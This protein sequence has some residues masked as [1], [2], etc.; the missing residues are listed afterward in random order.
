MADL[1]ISDLVTASQLKNDDY[2]EISQS[3]SGTRVSYK[4]T[5][6][7]I[8]VQ[9]ATMVD[10]TSDLNTT[11]KKITGAINELKN[12]ISLIPQFS[13]EVVETLP[14]EDISDTTIYLVPAEDPEVGNYYEEYI[15]VN[16]T[17]ELVGTTA[18]DLSDYYTKA[19]ADGKFAVTIANTQASGATKA[20]VGDFTQNGVTTSLYADDA[21]K[22][23]RAAFGEHEVT[24]NPVSFDAYL[25]LEVPSKAEVSFSPI[26]DLHGYDNPCVGG[27]GKNKLPNTYSTTTY[28]GITYT[29]SSDGKVVAIGKASGGNSILD[30]ATNLI[31][32]SGTYKINGISGGETST[33]RMRYQINGGSYNNILSGE[34]E[35]TVNGT[36]ELVVQIVMFSGY[37]CPTSGITFEP[38]IRLS[39]ETDDTFEPYSNICPI[40]GYTGLNLYQDTEQTET[41]ENTYT[42]TF[43]RTVFGGK[44]DFASGLLTVD[45]AFFEFDGSVDENWSVRNDG[46][47]SRRFLLDTSISM[48]NASQSMSNYLIYESGNLGVWGK[49]NIVSNSYVVVKDNANNFQDVTALTTYLSSHPLQIC[50]DLATPTEITL[51]SQEIELLKGQNV[52]W[53]DG[54]NVKLV[55]S[56][57]IKAYIDSKLA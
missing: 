7:A 17:W 52:L 47:T 4:A 10:F 12:L 15:H 37:S 18:V 6:L 44:Y 21:D 56:A 35:F 51:T 2:Y 43:G 8:A 41:P 24:G 48:T 19:Q 29:V 54:D 31:L 25:G 45:K 49:Y 33:Y 42:A 14:T 50:C 55:Y 53:T 46:T 16:N 39:T 28:R 36:D 9:I 11:S 38:M 5:L 23:L 3:E 1:R 13:I 30:I 22:V 57:D 40:S 32:P 26:Q 20:K 34:S 27:A